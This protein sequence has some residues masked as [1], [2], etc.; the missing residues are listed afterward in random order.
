MADREGWHEIMCNPPDE[1]IADRVATF[2][3]YLPVMIPK[4]D[5][6]N[7]NGDEVVSSWKFF[8]H[9]EMVLNELL[10]MLQANLSLLSLLPTY[11][12]YTSSH[13]ARCSFLTHCTACLNTARCSLPHCQ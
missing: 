5:D 13:A 9:F 10:P 7:L 1:I 12:V 4:S 3:E 8:E 6:G 11:A 2:N